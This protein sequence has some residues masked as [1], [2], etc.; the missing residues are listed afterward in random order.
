MKKKKL[1]NNSKALH[2]FSPHAFYLLHFHPFA[3]GQ[4]QR[5]HGGDRAA[6]GGVKSVLVVGHT[7]IVYITIL[8]FKKG[9]MVPGRVPRS[10]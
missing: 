1:S 8:F 9:K 2:S 5:L 6:V 7:A 10:D 3:G 4:G